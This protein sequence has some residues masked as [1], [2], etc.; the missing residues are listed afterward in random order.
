MVPKNEVQEPC[1]RRGQSKSRTTTWTPQ[2]NP[3]IVQNMEQAIT[4]GAWSQGEEENNHFDSQ[5][6]PTI[7]QS[8]EHTSIALKGTN[9]RPKK[10]ETHKC[11]CRM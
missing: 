2:T 4:W 5:R 9:D 8:K 11:S 1:D 6:S 7:V 3:T 10:G